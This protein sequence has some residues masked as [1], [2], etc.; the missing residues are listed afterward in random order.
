ME[1]RVFECLNKSVFLWVQGSWALIF[2]SLPKSHFVVKPFRSYAMITMWLQSYLS[3]PCA[4][5]CI[6]STTIPESTLSAYAKE[7]GLMMAW[8]QWFWGMVVAL[9]LIPP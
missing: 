4:R 8:E 7:N 2:K 9:I 3:S 1:S 6:G 5:C